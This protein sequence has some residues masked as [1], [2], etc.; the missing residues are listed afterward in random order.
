[1]NYFEYSDSEKNNSISSECKSS[2]SL[3]NVQIFN[4]VTV[5]SPEKYELKTRNGR[6]VRCNESIW[7]YLYFKKKNGIDA[8]N[9]KSKKTI[10]IKANNSTEISSDNPDFL[11]PIKSN[12]KRKIINEINDE[13]HI[14]PKRKSNQKHRKGKHSSTTY[15][16]FYLIFYYTIL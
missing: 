9:N 3:E 2:Q 1:M 15:R 16:K 14:V 8:H 10:L 5:S 4:T 12:K 7:K 6:R 13:E 11:K